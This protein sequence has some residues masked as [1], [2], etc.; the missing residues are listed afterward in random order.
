[1]VGV[2]AI[3]L[4]THRLEDILEFNLA[5]H[6]PNGLGKTLAASADCLETLFEHL[7]EHKP[8]PNEYAQLLAEM[9]EWEQRLSTAAA[10]A[11]V[12]LIQPLDP[13]A[14]PDFI[15]Q[16]SMAEDDGDAEESPAPD[17][18]RSNSSYLSVPMETVQRLLNLAGELITSTSQIA[19]QTQ[20]TLAFGK[21]LQQ[22]D[23]NIRQMLETLSETIDQQSTNL[24]QHPVHKAATLTTS[25]DNFDQLELEAYNDLHSASSLLTESIADNRELTRNLQQQIRQISEQVYQ[26]QRLQ[27]QLSETILRTRLVPIQSITARMERTVRET[28]RRTD[29]QASISITGQNLQIDTDILQGLTAPLLHMLR[30]AVDHGIEFPTTRE[31]TG[32]PTEGK[33]SLHFEQKVN[34]IHLTLHDDGQGLDVERIRARAVERGLL[35]PDATLSEEDTFRL[36]LQPGFTTRDQVSDISGRGVGMDVVQTAVENL[37]GLLRITSQPG[38]GTSLHIQV[39]LTLIA[40]NALLVRTGG[41]L[42]AVPGN[43]IQQ[44]LYVA[45]NEH[46]VDGESW[47]IQYQGKALDVLPL[48]RLLGWQA[49][50]PDLSKGHSLLIVDSETTSYALYVEE[51]LQPRDIV[52]KNLSPWL[53]LNQGVSGACIL[54]NGTVA[55]VVDLLRILRN[56]ESGLLSLDENHTTKIDKTPER[57]SILIVDDSLSNRKSL[58]LMVEQMGYQAITAVDGLEALQHLNG[59][60]IA[61][62]LT[63][64]EMPRMNGLEMTQ[65]IRIWPEKRHLPI[66]MITS[67]STNKHRQMAQQAGVDA[68]L[69]KPVDHDTLNTQIYKWL[70]TQLVA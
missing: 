15:L 23:E 44:L 25:A 7:Q 26:Q 24:N 64:L 57:V 62:V 31:A 55:P 42:V 17:M 56:L 38:Q 37:Q 58:S 53:N 13:V 65:A 49:K 30:N 9:D 28:C 11:P 70:K 63:D 14:L 10:E 34:Q 59:Q 27:R 68:Y 32:K 50:R 19:E 69:S 40:T 3:A 54:A 47:Q 2:E 8:L 61:L 48:A 41:N 51:T 46:I 5:Q 52:V 43:N 35:K 16:S 45:A 66:I 33:I 22:Q 4:F 6:L 1:M 67:R 29:K 12:A 60:A 18:P 21:Q 39:P 20:H 36:I